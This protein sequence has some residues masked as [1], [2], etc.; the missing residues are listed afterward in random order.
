MNN[1]SWYK[2][3]EKLAQSID[4]GKLVWWRRP[5][6]QRTY[7]INGATPKWHIFE[8]RKTSKEVIHEYTWVAKCGYKRDFEGLEHPRLN[9]SSR[10]AKDDR[11]VKCTDELK[12]EAKRNG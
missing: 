10:P 4:G 5:N 7:N 2:K 9:F 1:Q 3:L 12:A 6:F 11:C 8:E